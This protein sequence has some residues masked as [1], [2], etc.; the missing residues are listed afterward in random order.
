MRADARRNYDRLL[1]VAK[2][3]FAEHG[4]EAS[5]DDIAK[6]ASVGSGT[7][8][9]HFPTRL[10]LQE[11]VYRNEVEAI[12]T[13]GREI[14]D[15]EPPERAFFSWL[16]LFVRHAIGKRGLA[17]ALKRTLDMDSELFS[18]CHQAIRE[19]AGSLLTN[20]QKAGAVRTD[21]DVPDVLRLVSGVALTCSEASLS[22]GEADRLL[23]YLL[24]AMRPRS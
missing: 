6:R 22:D 14:I 19:V 11:A 1:E 15:S 23:S 10:A 17:M 21:L 13:R 9:R 2:E 24:D 8:Y 16:R 12:C 4:P 18:Y 3:S 7:L 5:L 20:A